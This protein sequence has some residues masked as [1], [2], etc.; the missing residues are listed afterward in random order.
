MTFASR[1]FHFQSGSPIP[2][3]TLSDDRWSS[4]LEIGRIE[5]PDDAIVKIT[6]RIFSRM[7]LAGG[8]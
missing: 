7:A 8:D 6:V 4:L 2:G 3:A 5:H 1:M